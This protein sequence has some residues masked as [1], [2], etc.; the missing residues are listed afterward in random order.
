M[1]N[2]TIF[3]G[4]LTLFAAICFFNPIG[5]GQT[6]QASALPEEEFV[7]V[8]EG[9]RLDALDE[10]GQPVGPVPLR[11]TG[12]E[13]HVSG[14]FTRVNVTQHYHNP[15]EHKIEAVYTFPLSHRAAVDRMT[16]TVGDRIVQGEVKERELAR[17]VYEAA[18][19]QGYVTSLLEQE[20]PNIFTQSVANIEPGAEV[21]IEI[22]YVEVLESVDGEYRFDFPMVVAPRYTPGRPLAG[23]AAVELPDGITLRRGVILPSPAEIK[24]GRH[25]PDERWLRQHAAPIDRDSPI[26]G[27]EHRRGKDHLFAFSVEYVNG[28][29]EVGVIFGDGVGRLGGRWFYCFPQLL[30]EPG[31][32]FAV[33]TDQV[34]DAD[35][36]TPMPV[37]PD[38]RAGHDISVRVRIDTGGP[39]ITQISSVSHDIIRETG[40]G[41]PARMSLTLAEGDSIPNRDFRL[42]WRLESERI[43]EAF[44]THTGRYGEDEGGFFTL[45][46]QPP[47]RVADEDARTREIIFVMDNSGSMR[48]ARVGDTSALGAAKDIINLAIDT[49]RPDDTFNVVSFNNT[50]DVLWDSPRPNTE[51]NRARAQNYVDERQGGGG[52]EMRNA[53]LRALRAGPFA[54][55]RRFEEP[56]GYGPMRIVLFLTDG[57]VS[58]DAAIIEAVR[59]NAHKTRVFTIGMSHSPNRHLLDEMARVGRGAVDYVL[60]EDDVKPIVQR[61]ADRIAT[62][63]LTDIRLEFGG[64][65]E[66]DGVLPS[67]EH[68]PDLFDMAPLVVHGRYSRP[69]SGTLTIRGLTGAGAYERTLDITLPENAPGHDTIATLWA[70]EKV[71]ELMREG[72]DA[73]G[74][75]VR[76]G[77]SFQIVTRHTSF[78]AVERMHVTLGGEPVLVRV[79]VEFPKGMSWEGIFGGRAPDVTDEDFVRHM[80]GSGPAISPEDGGVRLA[81]DAGIRRD[82]DARAPALQGEMIGL[83]RG[84]LDMAERPEA[85]RDSF[86]GREDMALLR[87][88]FERQRPGLPGGGRIFALA[89]PEQD[90]GARIARLR[91]LLHGD[92]EPHEA[93]VRVVYDES[94]NVAYLLVPGPLAESFVSVADK[95]GTRRDVAEWTEMLDKLAERLPALRRDAELRRLLDASLY[96]RVMALNEGAEDPD[97]AVDVAVLL[98]DPGTESL[99][100]LEDAGFRLGAIAESASFVVGSIELK[101]LE[102]FALLE[103]VRRVDPAL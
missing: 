5:V 62:P 4:L 32:P 60:P 10:K 64:G 85:V 56:E 33:P 30:P 50:L 98:T 1:R 59:E 26:I 91:D 101:G 72:G 86:A 66:V 58:N 99:R 35:R 25:V 13:V 20:R 100:K 93:L 31:H 102:S 92:D 46:L 22:S 29:S 52:T 36:V 96:A 28:E 84:A 39:W 75:I 55:L 80:R 70:R 17:R 45:I 27:E 47:E 71:G 77:E 83:A 76:L 97:A 2:M 54:E 89:L 16:M 87:R 53:V 43:E 21:T 94:Q 82:I 8:P 37:T 90:P 15:Y 73:V 61:F 44:L 95:V 14:H 81:A 40:V 103:G 68:M 24:G 12:V 9:G 19:R 57:L 49:M 79:P 34:P 23:D 11:H 18:R 41:S 74:E 48:G 51:E 65:L 42:A 63:V 38:R 7:L 69:G 78:V 3:M 88:S 6:P 67:A